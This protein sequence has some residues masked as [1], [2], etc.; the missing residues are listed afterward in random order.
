MYFR[1]YP[2]LTL[3]AVPALIAL[4]ALGVWQAQRAG[5]K[6]ERIAALE[7]QL[8]APPLRVDEACAAG[9]P[10]GRTITPPAGEGPEIRL[11]GHNNSGETG[12]KRF[13]AAALCGRLLLVQ[14]GFDALDIGGPGGRIPR[15][16]PSPPDRFIIQPWPGKPF[17]PGANNPA[18]NEW[19]W[20]DA[21]AMA[22][23]LGQP[24]LD[25]RAIIVPLDGKPDF[26]IRT[27]PETHVGYA[28]TWFGMAVAFAVIYG[29][30]HMRAGRLRFG[31][32]KA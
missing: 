19:Y 8:A 14:T 21:P 16:Q 32:K 1:P 7:Q 15:P 28:V 23:A 20:F 18:K 11:F 31:R 27:P 9:L 24:Q 26:L 12:W 29:L 17:M 25:A 13:Q 6:A 22:A 5:W 10:D 2:V 30:F 3:F 4:V